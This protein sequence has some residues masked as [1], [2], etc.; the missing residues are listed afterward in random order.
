MREDRAAYFGP[1]RSQRLTR[2]AVACLRD[3]YPIGDDDPAVRATALAELTALL[4]GDPAAFGVL[5]LR[6]EASVAA[7]RTPVDPADGGDPPR[8]LLAM[9]AG[10]A[11]ARRAALTMAVLVEPAELEGGAELFFVGG[12]VVRHSAAVLPGAWEGPAREGLEMLLR[13]PRG[14][15]AADALDEVVIVEDR[16]RA[17]RATGAALELAPGWEEAGVLEGVGRALG[18]LRDLP[19]PEPL[20]DD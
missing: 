13:E 20:T 15:L 1:L 8:A 11:R 17:L 18:A 4:Q 14:G 10:L 6:L 12:G 3:L 19:P 5:A 2:Q 9:L 7:G 16:L